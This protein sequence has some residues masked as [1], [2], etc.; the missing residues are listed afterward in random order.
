MNIK[1]KAWDFFK[2]KEENYDKLYGGFCSSVLFLTNNKICLHFLLNPFLLWNFCHIWWEFIFFYWSLKFLLVFCYINH[3]RNKY[4]CK[5]NILLFLCLPQITTDSTD[6]IKVV[7]TFLHTHLQGIGVTV[8]H[9]RDGKELP[10][11]SK[12]DNYDFDFQTSRLLPEPITI[13]GVSLFSSLQLY[14]S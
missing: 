14:I 9:F 4:Y 6:G 10:V 5:S 8:R 12:D 3:F 7:A 13:K 1:T 11:I 2:I